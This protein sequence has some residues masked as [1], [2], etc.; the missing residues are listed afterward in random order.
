MERE[1]ISSILRVTK[2]ASETTRF[3][4]PELYRR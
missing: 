1:S 4:I 2:V 3:H